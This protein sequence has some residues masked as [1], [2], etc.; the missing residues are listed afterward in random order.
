LAV[1]ECE[2][3]NPFSLAEQARDRLDFWDKPAMSVTIDLSCFTRLQ[4]LFVLKQF[5]GRGNF[6]LRLL[7]SKATYYA[8]LERKELGSGYDRIVILPFNAAGEVEP[9]MEENVLVASLG[10]EGGRALNAWRYLDPR[11]TILIEPHSPEAP[12]L[13]A[14]TKRQNRVLLDKLSIGHPGFEGVPLPAT[15]IAAA[16]K[17]FVDV[18][19][20][21]EE[22]PMPRAVYF[23]PGGPKPIAAGFALA[24]LRSNVSVYVADPPPTDYSAGYSVGFSGMYQYSIRVQNDASELVTLPTARS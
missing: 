6:R 8:S 24:A 14:V 10:H 4:L 5:L 12:D 20:R 3:H 7:Y 1:I 18:L 9:L 22:R 13:L 21:C 23:T 17:R 2:R 11:H 16:R 19:Q 15:D